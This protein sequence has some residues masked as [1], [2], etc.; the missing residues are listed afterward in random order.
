MLDLSTGFAESG[1]SSI[2]LERLK[3]GIPA[4]KKRV[5]D[6]IMLL[7]TASLTTAGGGSVT[8]GGHFEL[9]ANVQ[10]LNE[11]WGSII[12]SLTGRQLRLLFKGLTGKL[13]SADPAAMGA[14][15]G[16]VVTRLVVPLLFSAPA[17]SDRDDRAL[18]VEIL[19]ETV[20]LTF[21]TA[22]AV[23]VNVTINS[24]TL[25]AVAYYRDIRDKLAPRPYQYSRAT[26][27]TGSIN[28]NAGDHIFSFVDASDESITEAEWGAHT[29]IG[30]DPVSVHH[31]AVIEEY[32]RN[33]AFPGSELIPNAAEMI[34]LIRAPGRI[35]GGM[36][37]KDTH[38]AAGGVP[39]QLD[40]GTLTT[41]TVVMARY[42]PVPM[43]A[44]AEVAR[45]A[46]GIANPNVKAKTRSKRPIKLEHALNL[47]LKI[48]E[49]EPF[50]KVA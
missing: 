26:F 48:E 43:S 29:G 27:A 21:G 19:S 28:L 22:A 5:L 18:P 44:Q 23:G 8:P 41:P 7:V 25:R 36:S 31:Q 20:D 15:A 24:V 49:E 50:T 33:N 12:T 32:N 6:A 37:A 39:F 14:G 34:P 47:T 30:Y 16:P 38:G 45:I 13:A 2:R 42:L 35:Y 17:I 3:S 46:H 9:V 4:G 40:V 1:T 10:M 11:V